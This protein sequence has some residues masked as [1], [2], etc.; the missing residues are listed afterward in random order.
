MK[1]TLSSSPASK[2]LAAP[3]FT[4]EEKAILEEPRLLKDFTAVHE[5]ALAYMRWRRDTAVAAEP[6]L[7]P[8]TEAARDDHLWRFL[9]AKQFDALA[10]GDMYVDMLRWRRNA[11]LDT[12][13]ADLLAAN[14]L[15]FQEGALR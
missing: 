7:A 9:V 10:A 3:A 11:G 12:V 5:R 6:N 14:R 4:A 2:E 1:S 13:R 15:F 8:S